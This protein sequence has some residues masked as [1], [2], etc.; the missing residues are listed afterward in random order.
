MALSV[1]TINYKNKGSTTIQVQA[2]PCCDEISWLRRGLEGDKIEST[3]MKSDATNEF[4]PIYMN[5]NGLSM[6]WM[7]HGPV[8][9]WVVNQ[10]PGKFQEKL[11]LNFP[12]KT[13]K[14]NKL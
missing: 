1:V 10:S 5:E 3:F 2:A 12:L 6:W 8:G 7:W 11:I 14:N 4:Y 13:Y 9:H